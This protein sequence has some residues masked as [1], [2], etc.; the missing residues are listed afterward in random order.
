MRLLRLDLGCGQ[1]GVDL[2]PF[3]TVVH[4]LRP[5]ERVELLDAVTDLAA[6]WTAGIRGMLQHQGLLVELDGAGHDRFGSLCGVDVVVDAE[7]RGN[8]RSSSWSCPP[9]AAGPPTLEA[10]LARVTT[11]AGLVA[12]DGCGPVPVA[13]LGSFGGLSDT[14]LR[15]LLEGCSDLSAGIQVVVV[16]DRPAAH[17]WAGAVGL[18]RAMLSQPRP[19]SRPPRLG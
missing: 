2:H 17:A 1:T 16:T 9:L 8:Y 15:Q 19:L 12:A 18:Q 6:G 14:D 13:V 7:P 11:V 3:V 5:D 10:V 4:G